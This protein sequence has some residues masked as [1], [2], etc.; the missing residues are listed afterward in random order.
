M[1]DLWYSARAFKNYRRDLLR[2]RKLAPLGTCPGWTQA[3]VALAFVLSNINISTAM[4][5]TTR[6]Q[7]LEENIAACKL[8]L[9]EGVVEQ[10]RLL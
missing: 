2:A 5:S 1:A 10:I 4:F 3:Q 7:H 6:L 9:S 8:K